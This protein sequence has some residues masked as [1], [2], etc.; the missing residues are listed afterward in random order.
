MKLLAP[1]RLGGLCLLIGAV[2]A[3][4]PL[5]PGKDVSL[6]LGSTWTPGH[7]IDL[8]SYL[9]L[10]L[11]LPAVYASMGERL[12]WAGAIGYIAFVTRMALSMGSH[13]YEARVVPVLVRRPELASSITSNGTLNNIYGPSA[14]WIAIVL[15]AGGVLFGVALWRVTPA[16]RWPAALIAVG[17]AVAAVIPPLGIVMFSVGFGWLG[18]RLL[19]SADAR[20]PLRTPRSTPAREA[21]NVPMPGRR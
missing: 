11:G 5:S 18:S 8:A 1:A 21:T 12:G 3:L 14:T 2:L 20:S 16:M 19:K 15:S 7:L 9:F 6:A 4:S 13:L 17:S 10:L